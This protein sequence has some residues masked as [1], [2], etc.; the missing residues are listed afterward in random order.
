MRSNEVTI[1]ASALSKIVSGDYQL[2]EYESSVANLSPDFQSLFL[3]IQMCAEE[4]KEKDSILSALKL[5]NR[6]FSNNILL[7]N[8]EFKIVYENSQNNNEGEMYSEY[9]ETKFLDQYYNVDVLWLRN[10]VMSLPMYLSSHLI[11][12]TQNLSN[13]ETRLLITRVTSEI[14]MIEQSAA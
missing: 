3:L 6:N 11:I 5:I 9:Q 7:V 2:D 14:L 8:N 13:E 4:I 10:K 12:N 1:L